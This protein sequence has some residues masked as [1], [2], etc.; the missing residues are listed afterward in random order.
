MAFSFGNIF[1]NQSFNEPL[2]SLDDLQWKQLE[3]GY[4]GIAYDSSVALKRLGQTNTLQQ[5]TLIYQELWDELHHQGDIGLA[6]L[7]GSSPG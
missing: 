2:L 1:S 6:S 5:A 4:K 3:G 7:F